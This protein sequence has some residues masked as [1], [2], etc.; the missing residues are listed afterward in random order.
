MNAIASND[1]V[2]GIEEMEGTKANKTVDFGVILY[3]NC[4]S[5]RRKKAFKRK[6]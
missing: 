5:S 1:N 3:Y 6:G 2:Q 4:L